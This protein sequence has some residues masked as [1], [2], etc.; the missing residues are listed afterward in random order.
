MRRVLPALLLLAAALAVRAG[1]PA[2]AP[3][4]SLIWI[5]E[6][7]AADSLANYW[8]ALEDGS[9]YD[10]LTPADLGLGLTPTQWD[11]LLHTGD[12]VLVAMLR[13]R[14]WRLGVRPLAGTTFNRAEGPVT[15]LGLTVDRPGPRQPRLD[16]DAAYGFARRKASYGARLHLPA[17]TARPRDAEGHLQRAPWTS[18]SVELDAGRRVAHFGGEE[19]LPPPVVAVFGGEDPWHYLERTR[20]G[21]GLTARPRPW[22]T[23]GGGVAAVRDRPLGTATRWSLFGEESEVEPNLP[24]GDLDV[25]D[26]DLS[27]GLLRHDAALDATLTWSRVRG[28]G[29][30]AGADPAW[31]RRLDVRGRF[32]RHDPLRNQ[33]ILSAGWSSVD[34]PAPLQWTTW[35]G[36]WGTLR[37]YEPG[38]LVGDRGGHAALDVRW[39]VDPLRLLRV[40]LLK[41]WGLQPITFFEAGWTD[42][43]GVAPAFGARGRRADVGLGFSRVIGLGDDGPVRLTATFARPVGENPDGRGWRFAMGV[44][45]R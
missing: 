7:A 2:P 4:D 26:L 16:V 35:V 31:Y 32:A 24:A 18:L 42:D 44:D 17:A 40:P 30:P 8:R 36:G 43:E 15:G 9:W 21:A 22:L 23:L 5:S 37:G 39:N 41:D 45:L 38:E 27:L 3:V 33:W 11:S 6:T 10:P 12:A 20:L 29:F 1:E 19:G 14:P 25:T 13:G 34:R 28:G